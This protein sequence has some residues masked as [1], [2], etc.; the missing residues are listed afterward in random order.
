MGHSEVVP[1]YWENEGGLQGKMTA[2]ENGGLEGYTTPGLSDPAEA[3]PKHCSSLFIT[4]VQQNCNEA[5]DIRKTRLKKNGISLVSDAPC[6][7]LS[8]GYSCALHNISNC[9]EEL[10]TRPQKVFF[11]R[12]FKML[13]QTEK[14]I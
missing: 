6:R 1:T 2:A 4:T 11:K 7:M 8:Y 5:R 3:S 9:S 12:L 14:S 13:T 10:A